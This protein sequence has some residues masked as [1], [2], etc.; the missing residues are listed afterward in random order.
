MLLGIGDATTGSVP[1][2]SVMPGYT[3]GLSLWTTPIAA[4]QKTGDLISN[5]STSFSS[6]NLGYTAGVLTVPLVALM[7]LMG[8]MAS[9]SRR[10]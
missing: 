1:L 5:A 7:V 4:L 9:G 2:T 10:F 8:G 6:D 3:D